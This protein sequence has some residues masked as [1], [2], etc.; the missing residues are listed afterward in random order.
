M[1]IPTFTDKSII[2]T[3][4]KQGMFLSVLLT[5][6]DFLKTIKTKEP[7]LQT[8]ELLQRPCQLHTKTD[9]DLLFLKDVSI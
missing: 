3:F 6:S 2:F 8:N 9:A 7:F 5:L 4:N 1:H